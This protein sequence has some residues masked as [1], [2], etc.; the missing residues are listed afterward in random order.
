MGKMSYKKR[1]FGERAPARIPDFIDFY[2]SDTQCL[3]LSGD[4]ILLRH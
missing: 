1:Q 2:V 3:I 4:P